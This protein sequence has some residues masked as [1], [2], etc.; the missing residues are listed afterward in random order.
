MASNDALEQIRQRVEI[1]DLVREYVRLLPSGKSLKGLCPFHNEKT[2]SFHVTPA[3]GRFH[4]FGCGE[5]GDIFS[6]LQKVE[7]LEFRQVVERLAERAGVELPKLSNKRSQTTSEKEEWYS[8]LASAA[9]FYQ[10]Q[11]P[12]SNTAIAYL[13]D[14]GMD[15]ATIQHFG[16]GYSPEEWDSLAH[17]FSKQGIKLTVAQKMGLVDQGRDRGYFDKFRERL[18]FPIYDAQGRVIAFGGRIMGSGEPKYLNSP[19][20]PLFS[21]RSTLYGLHTARPYLLKQRT[22]ILVEGYFDV[23]AAQRAGFHNTLATLGTALSEEH[24]K[25]LHR[26]ADRV[27]VAYDSDNAGIAA[28]VRAAE[29]LVQ[30]QVD[31]RIAYLP[32]GE[33][34]DSL[35]KKSGPSAFNLALDQAETVTAFRLNLILRNHDLST[36]DG[37]TA[38]FKETIPVIASVQSIVERDRYVLMLAPY[39]PAYK[40]DAAR[41]EDAIRKDI[42]QAIRKQSKDRQK[43]PAKQKEDEPAQAISGPTLPRALIESEMTLIRAA[44][45]TEFREHIWE[46]IEPKHFDL[47]LHKEIAEAIRTAWGDTSPDAS[48]EQFINKIENEKIKQEFTGLMVKDNRPINDVWLEDCLAY[49]NR[50]RERQQ[51]A[52]L[53]DKL[54]D[55]DATEE[56]RQFSRLITEAHSRKN[57]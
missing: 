40:H 21:K 2:P 31:V 57:S 48:P 16:L 19:E 6:F 12:K 56:Q 52:A 33:D 45:E 7:N 55:T 36:A 53:R 14:R 32:E 34:P 25:L 39:A 26:W 18:M 24:A 10:Q 15:E 42:A 20:T 50:H 1:A 9:S 23:I 8:V 54:S 30:Q 5:S 11:L 51:S 35:L 47:P 49:L 37:L 38:M 44:C 22:A 4:C 28:A 46:W 3:L 27:I 41:A 43:T 29:E 17:H 13:R